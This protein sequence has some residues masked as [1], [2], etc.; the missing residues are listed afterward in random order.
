[1]PRNIGVGFGWKHWVVGQVLWVYWW[2]WLSTRE[3]TLYITLRF[4]SAS[5]HFSQEVL[6]FDARLGCLERNCKHLKCK[7]SFIAVLFSICMHNA[8]FA[9]QCLSVCSP[10][11]PSASHAKPCPP[12]TSVETQHAH[13]HCTLTILP[14]KRGTLFFAS[15]HFAV[16]RL[17]H[18]IY[19]RFLHPLHQLRSCAPHLHRT[20]A[21]R[22]RGTRRL[23]RSQP[24]SLPV[25]LRCS[26]AL[27]T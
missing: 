11:Q 8:W 15:I 13:T 7:L 6:A 27:N 1:M 9:C 21:S 10:A 24:F 23:L 20:P 12:A 19:Y 22:L 14:S 18:A 3:H 4:K 17:H 26:T 25:G 16:T 5:Y 2:S